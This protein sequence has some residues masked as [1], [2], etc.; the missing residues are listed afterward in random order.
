M[1]IVLSL[2]L[3]FVLFFFVRKHVGP[4]LLACLAGLSVHEAF[5]TDLA[6]FLQ[7]IFHD[8]P[9]ELLQTLIYLVLVLGFPI[10]I[11]FQSGHGGLYGILRIIEAGLF[12]ALFDSLLAPALEYFLPLDGLSSDIVAHINQFRGPILMSGIILAYLDILLYRD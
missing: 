11:Y 6:Y 1:I 2:V 8:A 3:L 5:S 4:T 10:L 7:G 9:I 12:T